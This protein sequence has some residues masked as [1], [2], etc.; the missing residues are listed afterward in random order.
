M[1]ISTSA[2]KLFRN[3]LNFEFSSGLS[4]SCS[5]LSRTFHLFLYWIAKSRSV[6]GAFSKL[7][8]ILKV[9]N[10]KGKICSWVIQFHESS[11]PNSSI[12][13]LK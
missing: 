13:S 11:V 6:F 1:N 10:D 12:M 3:D 8:L 7:G 5:F 2:R 9:S 4:S